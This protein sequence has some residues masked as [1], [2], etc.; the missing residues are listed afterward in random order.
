VA[1]LA[2]IA[3]PAERERMLAFFDASL[4]ALERRLSRPA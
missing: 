1:E 3:E 4:A 2:A